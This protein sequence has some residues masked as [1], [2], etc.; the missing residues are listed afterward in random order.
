MTNM[1]QVGRYDLNEILNNPQ[2][3]ADFMS[4]LLQIPDDI[5]NYHS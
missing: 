1:C 3:Y 2:M 4:M 5:I